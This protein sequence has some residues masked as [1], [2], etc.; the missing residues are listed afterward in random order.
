[1]LL[2][3]YLPAVS[4]VF[5]SNFYV[6]HQGMLQKIPYGW[7]LVYDFTSPV[8]LLFIIIYFIYFVASCVSLLAWGLH[9]RFKRE[10]KQMGIIIFTTVFSVA[11]GVGNDYILPALGIAVFP[12]IA[13]FVGMIWLFGL[14]ISI[15][16][17]RLMTIDT[18]FA[19]SEIIKRMKDLMVMVDYQ[20]MIREI[21][22][23]T[24]ATLGY[25][26]EELYGKSIDVLVAE[27]QEYWMMN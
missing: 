4:G 26:A 3:I 7:V 25:Q 12:V 8:V 6:Q 5:I 19:A 15:K 20:G 18:S 10:K 22:P 27:K 17:Y 14:W 16:K 11:L 9:S 24:C 23:H 21:S 2:M 1:M 13:P